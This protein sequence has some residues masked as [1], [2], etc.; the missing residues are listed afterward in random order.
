[1]GNNDDLKWQILDAK[2]AHRE[3]VGRALLLIEGASVQ[4]EMVP[5]NETACVFGR[6]Y[7]SDGQILRNNNIFHDI[8]RV[9]EELHQKYAQIYALIFREQTQ[10]LFSKLIGKSAS[11]SPA[12]LQIAKQKYAELNQISHTMVDLIDRLVNDIQMDESV[13]KLKLV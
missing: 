8:G 6:W 7:F 3:W 11:I 10:S 4:K 13:A 5:V 12:E 2:R 9:H 1:M